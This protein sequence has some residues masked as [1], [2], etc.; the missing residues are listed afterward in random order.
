MEA[1]EFSVPPTLAE[2]AAGGEDAAVVKR[3]TDVE[4]LCGE[5]VEDLLER[6]CPRP[7]RRPAARARTAPLTRPRRA[8]AGVASALCENEATC[9]T[10]QEQLDDIFS[11]VRCV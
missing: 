3:V 4:A 6:A 11:L 2:L 1:A 10:E 8:R 5:E 7:A 9:V